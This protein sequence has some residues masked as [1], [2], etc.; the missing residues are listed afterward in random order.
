VDN[1]YRWKQLNLAHGIS[2][3]K[4]C[5]YGVFVGVLKTVYDSDWCENP[6]IV[7][8]G[9]CRETSMPCNIA[10]HT[11]RVAH[12]TSCPTAAPTPNPTVCFY[13]LI[14]VGCILFMFLSF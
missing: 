2:S 10:P 1:A 4:V 8:D 12:Q 3:I 13:L 6:N 5:L 7:G 11:L 14:D 9:L